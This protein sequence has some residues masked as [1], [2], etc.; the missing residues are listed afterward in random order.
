MI[1][2]F[3]YYDIVPTF[4]GYNRVHP[5]KLYPD[6]IMDLQ[7]NFLGGLVGAVVFLMIFSRSSVA[8]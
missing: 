7:M 3:E 4:G 1:E 5:L 6:T 8:R 2:F